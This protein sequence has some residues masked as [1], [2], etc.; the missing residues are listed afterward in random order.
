MPI[1]LALFLG[2]TKSSPSFEPLGYLGASP[3]HAPIRLFVV[4]PFRLPPPIVKLSI[5]A[6]ENHT[7]YHPSLAPG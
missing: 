1:G 3:H 6:Q 4:S 5:R 2:L 7:N